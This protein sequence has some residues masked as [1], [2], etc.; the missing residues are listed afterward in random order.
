MNE[1]LELEELNLHFSSIKTS[2]ASYLNFFQLNQQKSEIVDQLTRNHIVSTNKFSPN[3]PAICLLQEPFYCKQGNFYGPDSTYAPA[4]FLKQPGFR[5]RA[6]IWC[7]KI[8][9]P[10]PVHQLTSRDSAAAAIHPSRGSTI[11]LSLEHLP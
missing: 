3:S 8:Y 5:A 2:G 11:S 1:E 4:I 6:A 9:Y 7:P 10:R